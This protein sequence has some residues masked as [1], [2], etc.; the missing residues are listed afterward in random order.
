MSNH[1][2]LDC[3]FY[4]THPVISS[5]SNKNLSVCLDVLQSLL[6]LYYYLTLIHGDSPLC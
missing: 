1:Y 4:S 6:V 5:R 2:T 3:V